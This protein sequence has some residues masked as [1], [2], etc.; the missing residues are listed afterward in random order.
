MKSKKKVI[1]VSIILMLYKSK[2]LN[3]DKQ[4]KLNV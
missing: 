1:N 4:E 3:L 2:S